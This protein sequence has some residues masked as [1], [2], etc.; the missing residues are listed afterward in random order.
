MHSDASVHSYELCLGFGFGVIFVGFGLFVCF[1][2]AVSDDKCLSNL[3]SA[4]MSFN[5]AV[6]PFFKYWK[7]FPPYLM[8]VV[9]LDKC[10][11]C[12]HFRSSRVPLYH[13]FI[14]P[15]ACSISYFNIFQ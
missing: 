15:W 2:S 8:N 1:L 7:L 5:I 10:H 12:S 13:V 11:P 14:L 3:Q 4:V 6:S 9:N